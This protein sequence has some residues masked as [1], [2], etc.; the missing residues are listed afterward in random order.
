MMLAQSDAPAGLG[1]ADLRSFLLGPWRLARAI[2]D[3]R[4]GQRGF[5]RG[6]ASFTARQD[7]LGYVETGRL[8]LG[9]HSG[10]AHQSYL[11]A[12]PEVGR[13]EVR[14]ADGRAFHV[15]DLAEGRWACTHRCGADLYRGSF[16]VAS[17]NMLRV[18]WTVAGPRKDFVSL[19]RY[20]RA[21]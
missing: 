14:F 5:V 19:S 18:R 11:Y 10:P 8:R 20:R 1:I 6:Q 16:E 12:F 9:A 21:A 15:L 17:P 3:R 4:G 13:A 2:D 7:G